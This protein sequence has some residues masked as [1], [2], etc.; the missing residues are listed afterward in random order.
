MYSYQFMKWSK[1]KLSLSGW[2]ISEDYNLISTIGKLKL[3]SQAPWQFGP[4]S[5]RALDPFPSC[6]P[7]EKLTHHSA[8]GEEKDTQNP[9]KDELRSG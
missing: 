7:W 8:S 1:E 5:L 4:Q 9:P 2:C 3:H 6:A